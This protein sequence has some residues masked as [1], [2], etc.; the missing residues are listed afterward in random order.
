MININGNPIEAAFEAHNR[1]QRRG[2]KFEAELGDRINQL[3]PRC[4]PSTT[5]SQSKVAKSKKDL[6]TNKTLIKFQKKP[7]N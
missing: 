5:S 4:Q 3:F 1:V 6:N 7:K 2:E